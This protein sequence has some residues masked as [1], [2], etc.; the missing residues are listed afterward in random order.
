MKIATN[1][2]V[3]EAVTVHNMDEMRSLVA[4]GPTDWPG[5]KYILTKEVYD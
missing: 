3:P 5:A 4:N 1:I 2:T